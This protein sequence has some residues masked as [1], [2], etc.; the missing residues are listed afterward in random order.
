MVNVS[1]NAVDELK[2]AVRGQVLLPGDASFEQARSIWNAMIDRHPAIILRCA[3]AADVR[4]GVAFARDNGLPLAIRGGGHNIGGSALCDDGVVLDLSQMKSVH[5]DPAARRA[6]VEPGATLH[7]FDHEAQAFGLATPLGINSTTGVAGL[8]LGG[9]FGWLSR[10]YGMTIDNLVSADVV[11]A[12]GEL[13]NTSADSH[14]DLFWAIRGGGGNFGVVTRF[15]FA[16]HPVGPL[17]YGG[18]VVLP[19]AQA[20]D[21]L[22]KYRAANAAMPEE[23]SVWAVLRL[24]PPLPFLP[25]EVHGKPVIVFAMC[26]TGPIENGPSA[27]EFVRAFGTPVGEHLGP[28]PFVA[29]Q[30]AFDPLLTPG[31]R[32]YWKSHNLGEIQD[33]LIDALLSAIDKLP[34]PQCEIFFGQIGAQTQRVPV[35][36]TAYSSR[37]TLYAMNVHGRWDDASD[38]ERCIAWARAFFDAAAPFALGSVY[39]NFMTQEEGGRVADA[40]G[41]NY[42]RLV[43]VKNRY[44]PR[45]LFRCNQ[46][47]R[48]SV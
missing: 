5:I 25:P 9:G 47:I 8:T 48:P 42:E 27:V 41:P 32:N 31:A 30:Q 45:N 37:D 26:Y 11:T 36:A 12:E 33:G 19:L 28:M 38:D 2:T 43:A 29:W 22:L 44:D 10:R 35:E 3:G 1:S 15:E 21:A 34:S 17:V 20:R 14:E 6:Y 40:Y 7:D 39:V 18:L 16:L 23:L 24:A 4:Q 46:N 13:L